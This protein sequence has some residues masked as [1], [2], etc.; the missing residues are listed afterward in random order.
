MLRAP[1]WSAPWSEI[2]EVGEGIS[3]PNWMVLRRVLLVHL[4]SGDEEMF[5]VNK[6]DDRLEI[7]R[8]LHHLSQKS[9]GRHDG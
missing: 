7:A 3:P 1:R 2:E 5:V 4:T 6:L 8:R 9:K